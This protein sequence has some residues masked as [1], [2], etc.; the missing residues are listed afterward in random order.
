MF[1][2][3]AVKGRIWTN[4]KWWHTWS[5]FLDAWRK[6]CVSH[7]SSILFHSKSRRNEVFLHVHFSVEMWSRFLLSGCGPAQERKGDKATR[8]QKTDPHTFGCGEHTRGTLVETCSISLGTFSCVF[9]SPAEHLRGEVQELWGVQ[10]RRSAYSSQHSHSARR[11]V[12]QSSVW[13][14][15]QL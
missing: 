13:F 15:T 12:P 2:N 10:G 9:C 4:R 7:F 6:G 8:V 1:T 11:S 3:R 14:M 5:S